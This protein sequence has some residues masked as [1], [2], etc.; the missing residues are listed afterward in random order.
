VLQRR[1]K[2]IFMVNPVI[3]NQISREFYFIGVG[4]GRANEVIKKVKL[5][6]LQHTIEIIL[7]KRCKFSSLS[8]VGSR[9]YMLNVIGMD[10]SSRK[11]HAS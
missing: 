8:G 2:Y 11:M 3:F 4:N 5:P 10:F 9:L 1:E 6:V 7:V